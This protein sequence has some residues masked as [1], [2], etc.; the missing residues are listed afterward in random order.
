MGVS[1]GKRVVVGL[2]ILTGVL[3][4]AIASGAAG[5]LPVPVQGVPEI[6][7]SIP[8]PIP[9][10]PRSNASSALSDAAAYA[11]ADRSERSTGGESG[12]GDGGILDGIPV[13]IVVPGDPDPVEPAPFVGTAEVFW[14]ALQA[15]TTVAVAAFLSEGLRPFDWVRWRDSLATLPLVSRLRPDRLLEHPVRRLIYDTVRSRAGVHYRELLRL[16]GVSNGTLSFHL[17]H[18]ERAG[19]VRSFR[20]RA[21]RVLL[22]TGRQAS[23]GDFLVS[24]RQQRIVEFLRGSPGASQRDVMAAVGMSRSSVS[25]NLRHL[26][27]LRIVEARREAGRSRYYLR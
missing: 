22:P 2:L 18:L 23:P 10:E 6:P 24:E 8:D 20:V 12:S 14:A 13:T 26:C 15:G 17:T 19:Y 3:V 25:Y 4:P 5:A 16:V 9:V 7:I 1:H 11:D 21:R 27:G